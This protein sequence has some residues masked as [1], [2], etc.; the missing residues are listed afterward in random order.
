ML[1]KTFA[2]YP[3]DGNV[4]PH[5]TM[6]DANKF[7][8]EYVV[9]SDEG[10]DKGMT[11][12]IFWLFIFFTFADMLGIQVCAHACTYACECVRPCVRVV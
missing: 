9:Q 10:Y 7:M 5:D 4:V 12:N 1:M 3:S 8:D 6:E 2:P 11:V